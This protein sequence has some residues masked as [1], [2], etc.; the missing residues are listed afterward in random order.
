VPDLS[1][2]NQQAIGQF[3]LRHHVWLILCADLTERQDSGKNALYNSSVVISPEGEVRA[4]YHKRRL[5]IF[6]EYV[7]L[8]KWLPFLKWFTPVL[9]GYTPGDR[10]VAFALTSLQ[11]TT[12]VLICF[13]DMFPAEAREH[14]GPD[15]DF[16][17]NLTNDGW[18]GE[19]PE[20]RQQ[21]ASAVFR[22]V[23]NGLPLVRCA[24]NGLTCWVDG[25]GRMRQIEEQNGNI[26]GRGFITVTVPLSAAGEHQQTIY[27]R[28]G[29]WFG[30]S[31]CALSCAVL[32]F[33]WRGPEMS[34]ETRDSV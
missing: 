30:W 18:F 3:L 15:I 5:V 2:E 22:A 4:V 25:Q 26:Y 19:G 33:R 12:S 32:I 9:E 6:G 13:E 34:T 7:P 8:E 10:P 24:N 20:Q 16:L 31:C 21:A 29:D 1:P 14:A 11:A 17:V 28:Y 27:N 23:E